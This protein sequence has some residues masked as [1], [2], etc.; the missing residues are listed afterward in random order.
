MLLNCKGLPH[1]PMI[2]S[3]AIM[4]CSLIDKDMNPG[5]RFNNLCEY[6]MKLTGGVINVGFNNSVY[7][8]EK[9]HS[10][11]NFALSYFMKETNDKKKTGFPKGTN[12]I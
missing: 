12:I 8:S 5:E 4:A 3:G 10:D 7:L 9:E 2:N 6:W 11:R 1:N